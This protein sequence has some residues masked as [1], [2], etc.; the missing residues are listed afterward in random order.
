ME[1]VILIGKCNDII[2]FKMYTWII[3]VLEVVEIVNYYFMVVISSVSY[4]Y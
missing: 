2:F 4:F 1:K 3:F